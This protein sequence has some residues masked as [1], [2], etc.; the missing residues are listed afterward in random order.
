MIAGGPARPLRMGGG[1]GSG[2]G[3]GGTDVGI[4]GEG[5]GDG[6][7]FTCSGAVGARSS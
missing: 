3:T 5:V 7:G 1:L 6:S 2:V 4:P